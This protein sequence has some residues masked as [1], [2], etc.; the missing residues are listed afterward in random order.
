MARF[1]ARRSRYCGGRAMKFD[2][3]E[4]YLA[5]LAYELR[6][7]GA[8]TMR[9]VEEA[10][11]HLVDAVEHG[12]QRGLDETSAQRAAIDQFGSAES[13]AA[14]F[15]AQ[16]YWLVDRLVLLAAAI[17]GIVI[18][19]VDS[20]PAWDDTGVTAF[21][22]IAASALCGFASPRRPWRCA[23]AVGMWILV[24]AMLGSASLDAVVMLVIVM[25]TLVG[26]YAGAT[27][28]VAFLRTAPHAHGYQIFHVSGEV[29]P[30]LAAA[31]AEPDT[32]LVPFL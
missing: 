15:I 12:M 26:A 29:D 27:M 11:G 31:I 6:R 13:V 4:A 25:C 5:A 24:F 20:R 23:L 18:A 22:L 8:S 1:R 28:R 21:S 7:H 19:Y 10:R 32:R 16:T 3:I 2:T 30:E 14:T 9:M 17:I